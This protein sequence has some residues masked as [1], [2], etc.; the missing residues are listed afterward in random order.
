[1][2][3][4]FEKV[5][6]EPNE[7]FAAI[8][9]SDNAFTHCCHFHSE[10]EIVL[11]EKGYCTVVSGEEAFR[12]DPGDVFVFGP[13]TPHF[14]QNLP[15]DSR[16]PEW[17]GAV[18]VHFDL[19]VFG[20]TYLCAPEMREV[21]EFIR[22]IE[23]SG[24]IL[25]GGLREDVAGQ[26]RAFPSRQGLE[27]FIAL[28]QLLNTLI[29]GSASD[30]RAISAAPRMPDMH[31]LDIARLTRVFGHVRDHFHEEIR[32][33]DVARLASMT[34]ASFSRFFHQKSGQTFQDYLCGIRIREAC[35][36]L[37]QTGDTIIEICHA[38]GFN[39]LSN[40]NRQFRKHLGKPP[41]AYRKA[42][43]TVVAVGAGGA[44]EEDAGE[45]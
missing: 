6:I 44:R 21:D 23:G 19:R 40:F 12:V 45:V 1:M 31:A 20:D 2:S 26:L 9:Q 41:L 15:E 4:I 11:I 33:A 43:R 36:R 13:N 10:T 22:K 42:W 25:A 24:L 16:G 17:A 7:S 35:A 38:S 37:I 5:A 14:T 30:L 27:R 39:N 32:L 18:L 8:R 28:Q 34:E 3:V 29:R